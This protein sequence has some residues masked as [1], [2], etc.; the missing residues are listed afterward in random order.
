M[1][2]KETLEK[3]CEQI[4]FGTCTF[5]EDARKVLKAPNIRINLPVHPFSSNSWL[6]FTQNWECEVYINGNLVGKLKST[7]CAKAGWIS[8][9]ISKNLPTQS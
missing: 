8:W 7:C 2:T 3:I 5:Y 1:T 9:E 4:N 6:R